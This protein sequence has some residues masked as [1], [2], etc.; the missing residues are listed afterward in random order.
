MRMHLAA[1]KSLITLPEGVDDLIRGQIVA[2]FPGQ[3]RRVCWERR[4]HRQTAEQP[5]GRHTGD[6]FEKGSTRA[7]GHF[8]KGAASIVIFHGEPPFQTQVL[9]G[10]NTAMVTRK[11]RR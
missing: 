8:V 10:R 6:G 3:G 1:P 9:E 11:E 7:I 2:V 5:D 4:C